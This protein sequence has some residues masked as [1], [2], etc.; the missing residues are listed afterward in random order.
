MS[1]YEHTRGGLGIERSE[2][3]AYRYR[4]SVGEGGRALLNIDRVSAKT[5]ERGDNIVDTTRMTGRCGDTRAEG[6]LALDMSESRVSFE[7]RDINS[8]RLIGIT[9][10]SSRGLRIRGRI[11]GRSSGARTRDEHVC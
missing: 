4:T 9:L 10:L 3:V 11:P 6:E 1:G 2:Y 5:L 7:L 8:G